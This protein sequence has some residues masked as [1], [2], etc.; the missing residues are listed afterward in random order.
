VSV[1]FT[2]ADGSKVD[3][4]IKAGEM[5]L[6]PLGVEKVKAQIIPAK[7][8]DIGAG[9]GKELEAILEGG[10][11]GVIIDGRGRPLLLPTD[12]NERIRKLNEWN[13]AL[14]IYPAK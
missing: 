5:K 10:T 2:R 4:S 1:H 11:V 3:E 9:K 14:N 8:F 7:Q 12:K 6:I 13:Q